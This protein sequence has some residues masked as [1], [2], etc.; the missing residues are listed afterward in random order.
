MRQWILAFA[1][2][3]LSI[4][5][6]CSD[7]GNTGLEGA[8]RGTL[9]WA[10]ERGTQAMFWSVYKNP[11]SVGHSDIVHWELNLK[12]TDGCEINLDF[13]LLAPD[14]DGSIT[15]PLENVTNHRDCFPE[16]TSESLGSNRLELA[17]AGD[18]IED[19]ES[20]DGTATLRA[21][22]GS[23]TVVTT[24]REGTWEATLDQ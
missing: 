18:F 20:A 1:V 9:T 4:L 21:V 23:G 15:L 3:A 5:T 10:D 16:I 12:T 17:L 7:S 19:T 14:E 2:L 13:G 24:F 6:G 22:D 11:A 8:W